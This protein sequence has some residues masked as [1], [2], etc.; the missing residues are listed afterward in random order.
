MFPK[1]DAEV[2]ILKI[3]PDVHAQKGSREEVK[4]IDKVH[5]SMMKNPLTL[6]TTFQAG[7]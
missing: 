5:A 6:H 3:L 1:K 4:V 2:L 7:T